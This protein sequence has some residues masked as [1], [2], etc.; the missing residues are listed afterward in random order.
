MSINLV[1]MEVFFRRCSRKEAEEMYVRQGLVNGNTSCKIHGVGN[2]S[3]KDK[4]ISSS[5]KYANLYSPSGVDKEAYRYCG[6]IKTSDGTQDALVQDRLEGIVAK[7][8]RGGYGIPP[9]LLGWFNSRVE[10]VDIYD[11]I[12]DRLPKKF[13]FGSKVRVLK[14]DKYENIFSTFVAFSPQFLEGNKDSV[15][16]NYEVKRGRTTWAKTSL[17]WT[18]WRSNWGRKKCQERILKLDIDMEYLGFLFNEAISHKL[19]EAQSSD[20]MYQDDP[21]RF[22]IARRWLDGK[23]NYFAKGGSTRHFA[24]RRDALKR[25]LGIDGYKREARVC[26]ITNVVQSVL[27]KKPALP[28][29]V[30][31][32]EIGVV[33]EEF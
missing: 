9:H 20:I 27:K 32:E 17:L 11:L 31:Y 14:S 10:G 3:D 19:P 18:L 21:D 13:D 6:V 4:W 28:T 8:P 26:D 25:Y 22:I 16:F 29:E 33:P 15:F 1:I 2:R 30:L 7:G 23:E 24:F 12:N 5:S